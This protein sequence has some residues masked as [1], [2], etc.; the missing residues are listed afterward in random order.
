MTSYRYTDAAGVDAINELAMAGWRVAQGYR[1][2]HDGRWVALM[3]KELSAEEH[4][5]LMRYI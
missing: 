1:S 4:R 5:E 3:E 2:S